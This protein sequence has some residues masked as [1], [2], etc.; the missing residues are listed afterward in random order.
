MCVLSRV[1]LF[2]SPWNVTAR[3]LGP[4]DF[5][6]KNT[7]V[8]CHFLLQWIFLTQGSNACLSCIGRWILYCCGHLEKKSVPCV[9]NVWFSF[10]KFCSAGQW[11]PLEPYRDLGEKYTF[12][13]EC[14]FKGCR[15]S[16]LLQEASELPLLCSLSAL[17]VYES[18]CPRLLSVFNLGILLPESSMLT[19]NNNFNSSSLLLP[20]L[21]QAHIGC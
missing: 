20:A 8:G 4:W 10:T 12:I 15:L 13:C 18:T 9:W 16:E 6:G 2:A 17:R 7:G 14:L 5:P 3:L 1:L 19:V 21:S 11:I